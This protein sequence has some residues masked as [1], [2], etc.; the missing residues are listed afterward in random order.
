MNDFYLPLLIYVKINSN[1]IVDERRPRV[2]REFKLVEE[3]N[4]IDVM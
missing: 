3:M 2:T 1:P 4:L